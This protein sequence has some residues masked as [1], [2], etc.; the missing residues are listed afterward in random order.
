MNR[1]QTILSIILLLLILALFGG[2]IYISIQK[3]SSKDISST[4][5]V[6]PRA[7]SSGNN[8][9]A[10]AS[11]SVSTSSSGDGVSC[12]CNLKYFL[13]SR[14]HGENVGSDILVKYKTQNSQN[15][16]C[17]YASGKNDFEIKNDLPEYF[18]ALQGS[19]LFL[20][21]GTG[22]PPRT[23]IVYDLNGRQ[24]IYTDSY[25]QPVDI[26]Q[27]SIT[28]WTPTDTIPNDTNCPERSKYISEGLSVE[29]DSQ[30]TLHLPSLQKEALG[31]FRCTPKQ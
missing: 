14:N 11:T 24:K 5:K 10:E 29:I 17:V 18:L 27:N 19:F 30:V 21:S 4:E 28:Y 31:A 16:P 26:E 7:T 22:P 1:N 13:F 3:K 20:D 8:S 9:Q 12:H 6:S 15:I 23:L 25:E 2:G